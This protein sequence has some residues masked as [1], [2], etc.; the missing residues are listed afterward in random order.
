M[1]DGV[2]VALRWYLDH[3]VTNPHHVEQ[4]IELLLVGGKLIQHPTKFGLSLEQ[5]G[6]GLLG[7]FV[8]SR[9]SSG[10][11]VSARAR[12]LSSG[13]RAPNRESLVQ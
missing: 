10:H 8:H 11:L 3:Y 2:S 7:D 5:L 4:L 12:L 9:S 6:G 1:Q 13:A